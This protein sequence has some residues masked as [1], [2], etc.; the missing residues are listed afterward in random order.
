MYSVLK[1]SSVQVGAFGGWGGL[2]LHLLAARGT[3]ANRQAAADEQ[4]EAGTAGPLSHAGLSPL[5]ILV[6]SS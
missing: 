2:F 6:F 3:D 5:S 4:E 1:Q